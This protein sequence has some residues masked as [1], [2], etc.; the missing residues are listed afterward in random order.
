MPADL[1]VRSTRVLTPSGVAP[2]VVHVANG[3]IA[4]ISGYNDY[5]PNALLDDAGTSSSCPGSSTRT[6][7][8]TNPGGRTGRVCDGDGRRGAGG[9]TTIVDMP[10]NSVPATTTLAGSTRSAARD[11]RTSRSSSGAASCRATRDLEAARRRRRPRLQVSSVAVG[12]DE[13]EYVEEADLRRRAADPGGAAG[14]RCSR[15]RSGR[16]RSKP[17]VPRASDPRVLRHVARVAPARRRGRRDRAAD[18]ALPRVPHAHP[19]RPPL[20][21]RGAAAAPRRARRG[22]ADH[23]RDLPALPD[24]LRRRDPRRR[25]VVQVRAADSR[26][27]AT[28]TRSGRRS[29]TATSIS[30][31]PIT[32]VPAVDEGRRR[33]HPRLGRDR[34]ARAQPAGGL[35]G[36]V[37]A[38]LP[39]ARVAQWLCAAPARLAGLGRRKGRS[40]RART[41]TSSSGI[42]TRRSSSTS[43]GCDQRHKR[44]P[45]AGLTLRGRVRGTYL[46]GRLVYSN[47]GGGVTADY[48]QSETAALMSEFTHL[49]D[50]AS[51]RLGGRAVA[52]NDEFFARRRTCSSPSPVFIP[53]KYTD[54]GKWMD[55]WETRRRR[56]P[57]HDWCIVTLGLPGDRP[58]V[59]VDTAFFRGNYP[60]ALLDRRL[61]PA[62]RRRS[63]A[64]AGRTW[65]TDPASAAS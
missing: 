60:V 6:C 37:G 24:V 41:P 33:F 9:I 63:A 32:P 7:T 27:R 15:T 42:P 17:I 64:S 3:R 65:T 28:A 40:R 30:S 18:H 10:L 20:D 2:A 62:A 54:R 53:D 8:S 23:R 21:R 59:V 19:H 5:P 38:G 45:Y 11:A 58:L 34:G 12:V 44:T 35:D 36:R 47:D 29:W 25:D 57:G 52:A 4:R 55:G 1:I 46:R 14:C 51:A 26:A 39:L 48:W 22:P 43:A 16:R 50:L 31:R 13:F 49:I 61:R 56:T